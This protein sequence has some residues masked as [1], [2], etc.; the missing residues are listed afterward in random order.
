MRLVV[1]TSEP[2]GAY[3]LTPLSVDLYSADHHFIH[4]VPYAE[5][6]QGS[7]GFEVT[8]DLEEALSADLL[9]IT[10]GDLS[11][12]TKSLALLANSQEVP[13]FYSQLALGTVS[14]RHSDVLFSGATFMSELGMERSPAFLKNCVNTVTGNPQLDKGGRSVP[15]RK[16]VL[17]LSTS[18][19]SDR[20]PEQH[21]LKLGR[22]LLDAGWTVTVRP[23]P[24]ER[25][26][27]WIEFKTDSNSSFVTQ[28]VSHAVVVGY[29]G[30]LLPLSG[31]LKRPTLSLSPTEEFREILDTEWLKS[32]SGQVL[33]SSEAINALL[34]GLAPPS[35]LDCARCCGPIGSSALRV[36]TAW[37][38]C[39]SNCAQSKYDS[40]PDLRRML[41]NAAVSPSTIRSPI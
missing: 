9:V 41:R 35:E 21:L 2:L 18:D 1:A 5:P 34:D 12:W 4:L 26:D 28:A 32:V 8:S 15:A 39:A 29:P 24:R 17:L 23:H 19:S 20:D 31:A 3:H 37:I 33:S 27:T 11:A 6:L 13:V 10:G 30:S 36:V 38:E 7:H 25:T 14:S 40:D 16:S 22:A